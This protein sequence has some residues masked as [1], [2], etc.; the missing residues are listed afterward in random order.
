ML[1]IKYKD[2][3]ISIKNNLICLIFSFNIFFWGITFNFIQLRFLIFLLIFPILL[4]LNK[5]I[6]SKLIKYFFISLV[7]FLHLFFQ[8]NIFF[9]NYLYSIFGLFLIMVIL[10][11]YKEFFLNNLDKIIYFFLIF[12]YL[13]IVIQ[14]FSFNDYFKEVS[15]N[16]VGC[17]SILKIFFKEN[18][19]LAL[20]APSVI[21]YLLF[22]SNYNKFINYFSVIIFLLICFVN[23]SLTLYI[24][25][26]ILFFSLLFF[27]LKLF[28]FK[29]FFLILITC[30]ALFKLYTDNVAKI[31]VTDFFNKNNNINL[32][33]EVYKTSYLVAKNTIFYKPL[34]YGFNNYS[35][36]FD[37]F[38]S[39]LNIYNKEVLL[40][41]KKDA[42]NNFS[43]IVT[44]FGIFS[45]FFFYFLISFLFNNKIDNKI[46]IFLA[47]PIIIQTFVRGAGYFNGG[48]ILFVFFAFVLWVKTYLN[49]NSIK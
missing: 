11:T 49:I 48:F 38:V 36:A 3:H 7:V 40:L 29:I 2:L 42:S 17:F 20:I 5:I 43:K 41:N 4:N 32:S 19:H 15:S 10:D 18:S 26:V 39:D 37:K 6:I 25:L 46:K 8:S 24:G 33:T 16:C 14:F 44:E 34:G 22:I 9:F 28:K 21:F 23:P 45:I 1:N 12:F 35:E 47:L 27:K 31:K 13:F 30:F